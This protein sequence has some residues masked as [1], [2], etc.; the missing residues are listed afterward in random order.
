MIA[1]MPSTLRLGDALGPTSAGA[2]VVRDPPSL[3]A[4]GRQ[5]RAHLVVLRHV[6]VAQDIAL[7]LADADAGASVILVASPSEA[8]A[9]LDRVEAVGVAFVAE[10]PRRFAGSPLARE[11]AARGGRAVLIGEDAEAEGAALGF[12]VLVRPFTADAVLACLRG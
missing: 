10:A 8:L 5:A 12:K 11:V 6:V 9:A 7:T 4:A 1:T 3:A 2:P